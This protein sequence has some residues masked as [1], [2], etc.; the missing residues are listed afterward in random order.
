MGGGSVGRGKVFDFGGRKWE[1][2]WVDQKL[3]ESIAWGIADSDVLGEKK[4][5]NGDSRRGRMIKGK[6]PGFTVGSIKKRRIENGFEARLWGG[7]RKLPGI[8]NKK[9]TSCY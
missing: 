6:T 8:W 3:R 7:G 9:K 4:N 5:H 2:C 1:P